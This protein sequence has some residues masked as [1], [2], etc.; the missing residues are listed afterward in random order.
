MNTRPV[1]LSAL[2][3]LAC[4]S[5][6]LA[7]PTPA[8][9]RLTI[10]VPVSVDGE[11]IDRDFDGSFENIRQDGKLQVTS[12]RNSSQVPFDV[13]AALE[14]DLSAVPTDRDLI[15]ASFVGVVSGTGTPPNTTEL[16]FDLLGYS[17]NGLIELA[18]AHASDTT[19]GVLT[20][21]AGFPGFG[22]H[23]V[24]LDREFVAARLLGGEVLGLLARSEENTGS[25]AIVS[26]RGS[27]AE[28]R[29]LLR[30]TLVPEPGTALLLL[31][32]G[33]L[34]FA[35]QGRERADQRG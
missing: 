12:F 18:D 27:Q 3:G 1:V 4:L 26:S 10:E 16:S 24:A 14:F 25:I 31:T 9:G 19:V 28:Q 30:L 7:G 13:R 29:P 32:V 20:I 2:G 6:L 5:L 23:E 34:S 22:P 17:G 15:S 35:P 8:L 21:P 11:L 33:L